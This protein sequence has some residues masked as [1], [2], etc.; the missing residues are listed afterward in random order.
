M[1]DFLVNNPLLFLC[2]YGIL[3][4]IIPWIFFYWIG[5]YGSPLQIKWIGINQA[6]KNRDTERAAAVGSKEHHE[7]AI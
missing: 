3:F 1:N 7:N 2:G 6:A 5:R 4:H